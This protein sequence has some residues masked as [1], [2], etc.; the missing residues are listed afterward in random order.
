MPRKKVSTVRGKRAD[1]ASG[2]PSIRIRMYRVGFGDCF[3]LTLG[4][5]HHILVD[6]G[7]H[8]RGNIKV[9]GDSLID[10]AFENIRE[11]TGEK[12]DIVIATHAHQD[13]VSGYGKFADEFRHFKEIGEVWLPWTDDLSNPTARK[14]HEKKKSFVGLLQNHLDAKQDK[15]AAAAIENA[16][17]N[18]EA[19]QALRE[20]FG[21]AKVPYLR[22]GNE[23]VS[24]AGLL[25]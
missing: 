13:H 5:A 19:M 10:H 17:A 20:G 8:S 16:G 1:H 3:L 4:G 6:C 2:P 24:P 21:K 15:E 25:P 23:L 22:A 11:V 12:L 7:V 18:P 9:N 14:W